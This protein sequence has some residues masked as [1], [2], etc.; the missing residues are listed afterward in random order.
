[1]Q[2][3][4]SWL[5]EF[6]EIDIPVELLAERLTLAGLEVE[7]LTYI[8]LPQQTV[9]GVHWPKSD[10]L[11]W[12]R[13]KLVLG[14]IREVKPHPNA[15]RLVMALVD[16]GGVELEQTVTG[17]P[18]L[19]EYKGLGPL[20]EPLW[21]AF[22]KEG[23][24]VWDGHS[25]EPKRM[26]LKEKPLRGVPNR[27]MV[28]SDKELG[29]SGEHE[30]IMLLENDRKLPPGTPMQ[31]VLGDVILNVELTPN[32]AR[33]FSILGV[34]REVAALLDKPVKQ[35]D[36]TVQQEGASILDQITV[37]IQEPQLNP[38][39]T[40]MLLRGIQI[41]PSPAWMQ[42]RLR[43]V[44]Q[45]PI[46]NIVDV[47]NYVMFEMG[48]PLHAFDYD[49]LKARSGNSIPKLITRLARPGET[50]KTLDGSE[51]NLATVDIVISDNQDEAISLAA[52]MGG[53]DTEIGDDTTTVLLEAANWNFISVRRT[54][55]AQKL[56][57]EASTR[58]SRGVHPSQAMLGVRRGIELMR[59]ISGGQVAKD[60]LDV[61]P[62]PAPVVEVDLPITETTR[63]LGIQFTVNETA[64]LL[65][66]QHFTVRVYG[67]T[68]KV[69]VPDYRQ[70]ISSDTVIGQADLA[71]EIA[72]IYGYDRIPDT[73][74]KDEMP[75]QWANTALER[76]ELVRD[77]LVAL[78]LRENIS[79]RL[80]TPEQESRL[81][82]N[83]AQ[84]PYVG[85]VKGDGYVRIANPITPER[86]AL[87]QSVLASVMDN[88]LAN[89]RYT[90]QQQTF[91]IGSVYLQR[92]DAVL[93]DEPRR[94]AILMT[95]PRVTADWLLPG[96]RAQE[97]VDFYDLKGLI[98]GLL[99]GLQLEGFS[100][101]RSSHP[102]LHP[103]RAAAVTVGGKVIG[104]LGELHP[105]VAR[106][107][108]WTQAPLF[109]ADLDLEALLSLV[110][111]LW[112][113]SVLPTTP[114]VLQDIA[115]VVPEATEAAAV[116]AVIRKTGGK[117]LRQVTLFDVYR[118][119]SIGDGVKSLAYS[120]VYQ[121]EDRT[122]KDDEV[123]SVHKKIVKM[124]ERELGAKLR[125]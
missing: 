12:D 54:A 120:L 43:A 7:S 94:L 79:Y 29:I 69:I 95:G 48:Q 72:R 85:V 61:Y 25:D 64:K 73:I 121:A 67:D 104:D 6:V 45:R 56:F 24:E 58:F 118:G 89:A 97:M 76:E 27:C 14:A 87:R 113:V 38:R 37:E 63:L 59:Q 123:A 42:R 112:A 75:S 51:R 71:E 116:E 111:P 122:L 108:E 11:V 80:T 60:T 100:F 68:L 44:G 84:F 124:C 57:S 70:D 99:R 17:A 93:P 82:S 3:P 32:L 2:V 115:L 81:L 21:T 102:S 105:A 22:A 107:Y 50:L 31:D 23:A 90:T 91:E 16:Y 77:V 8:G 101:S 117:L 26:I 49:K 109:V 19:F 86:S 20:P 4:L 74:M 53:F 119:T 83:G 41:G 1:M 13:E 15:D 5:K 34:A 47:T 110:N 39:F 96:E 30:G 55:Q 103:G 98:E 92:P 40:L 33:C 65:E 62:Q 66:Q 88:A 35:P 10:H 18:N 114:P 106:Q 36:F 78:G 46:N 9:P 52:I 125:A 28:C